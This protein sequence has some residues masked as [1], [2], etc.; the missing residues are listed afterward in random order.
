MPAPGAGGSS[1]N[2]TFNIQP[3]ASAGAPEST[4]NTFKRGGK[5]SSK[6][7]MGRGDGCATKGKTKGRMV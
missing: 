1:T 7:K 3:S 2:Q 4:T 6:P 5:V